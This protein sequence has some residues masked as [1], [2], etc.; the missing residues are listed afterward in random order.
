V[1]N[2]NAQSSIRS[3]VTDDPGLNAIAHDLAELYEPVVRE[4]PPN[5][6]RKLAEDLGKCL[7]PEACE[8]E[9]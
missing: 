1:R 2:C 6:L 8:G 3:N 5:R 9:D 4:T 7:R